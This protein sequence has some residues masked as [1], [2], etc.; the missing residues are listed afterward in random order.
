MK[1]FSSIISVTLLALSFQA[2]AA[3]QYKID[4]ENSTINFATIKKQYIVEPAELTNVS[5]MLNEDGSFSVKAALSS[6]N[7][8]ISIRNTRLNEIFFQSANNPDVTISGKVSLEDVEGANKSIPV[9]VSLYGNSKELTVPVTVL[10][11][12]DQIIA[13]TVKPLIVKASEFG[14]PVENLNKLAETVGGITLSDTVPV[15][16]VL[17]FDK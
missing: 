12:D 8:G 1:I 17:V 5:G 9:N 13:Y 11:N 2:S 4:S 16:F 7:T 14:I 15:S 6:I 3:D 10:K